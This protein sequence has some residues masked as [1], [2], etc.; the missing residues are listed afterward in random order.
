MHILNT[1]GKEIKNKLQQKQD[2]ATKLRYDVSDSINII[3]NPVE[4]MAKI[5]KVSGSSYSSRQ[6]VTIGFIIMS[7]QHVFG[8]M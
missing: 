8:S 2:E 7:N 1:Y 4:D 6:K 3:L 5:A